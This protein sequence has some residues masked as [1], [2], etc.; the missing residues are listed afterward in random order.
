MTNGAGPR[1]LSLLEPPQVARLTE[2][3]SSLEKILRQVDRFSA[4]APSK[5]KTSARISYLKELVT[6]WNLVLRSG[7]RALDSLSSVAEK[8]LQGGEL[9]DYRHWK[10]QLVLV[11]DGEPWYMPY[12]SIRLLTA[13]E[14]RQSKEMP[15]RN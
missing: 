14:E 7:A 1:G 2:Y 3:Y 6:E 12:D 10:S 11:A 4:T 13:E 15:S 5:N 9:D 8:Q